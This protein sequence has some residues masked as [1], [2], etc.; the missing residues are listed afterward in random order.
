M[1]DEKGFTLEVSSRYDGF[2][3]YNV[4]LT[5]GC[6]DAAGNRTGFVSE[7]SHITDAGSNLA[8]KPVEAPAGRIVVLSTPPCDHLLCYLY[9]IP[10]T[11]P[12]GR[13]IDGTR[14]FE[15]ELTVSFAGKKLRTETRQINQ[16]S[17][18]SIEMRIGRE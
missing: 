15:I 17:G 8:E 4:A 10:H 11:L 5:C 16:W 2:W 13:E 6:F 9:I 7:E 1:A 3:R 14:P 18:T 12:T